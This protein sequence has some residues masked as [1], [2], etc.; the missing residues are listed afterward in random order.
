MHPDRSK[1]FFAEQF[2]KNLGNNPLWPAV[3]YAFDKGKPVFH[4]DSEKNEAIVNKY[5]NNDCVDPE[6]CI[7]D[8]FETLKNQSI[9]QKMYFHLGP[10]AY[11]DMAERFGENLGFDPNKV[12]IIIRK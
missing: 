8:M 4:P 9:P 12:E 7:K 5:F 2:F 1:E 11:K 6:Q 3:P 10:E